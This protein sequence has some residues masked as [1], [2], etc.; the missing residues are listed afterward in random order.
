MVRSFAPAMEQKAQRRRL[1]LRDLGVAVGANQLRLEYQPILGIEDRRV[2]SLE[3]LVRWDHPARGLVSPADFIPLAEESDLIDRLG[4]W[5]LQE[6]CREAASWP[7]GE[8]VAVNISAMQFVRGQLVG[9]VRDALRT[10]GL[11]AYRLH[12]EITETA[13]LR[14]T[15]ETIAT[16]Q[17]LRELG[18][19]IAL[20]DFGTGYSSLSHLCSFPFDRIKIDRSFT[21]GATQ[22][23]NARAVIEAI[24]A[25]GHELGIPTTAEGVETEEQLSVVRGAGCTEVQGFLYARPMRPDAARAFLERT[26]EKA[27]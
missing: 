3:A 6:A 26:R 11:E 20:D 17:E 24:A 1:L 8:S 27:A 9:A 18:A 12:L 4:D 10:S 21:K 19:R 22:R 23:R 7:G 5:V 15:E 13:L 25:L 14:E 16:L 2:R